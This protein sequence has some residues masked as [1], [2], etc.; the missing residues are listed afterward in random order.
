MKQL[1]SSS[2]TICID[3]LVYSNVI[4]TLVY[5]SNC[6]KGNALAKIS[7][8]GQNTARY[9]EHV[10]GDWVGQVRHGGVGTSSRIIWILTSGA[11]AWF[12]TR[13]PAKTYTEKDFRVLN[14]NNCYFLCKE[15][16]IWSYFLVFT[17]PFNKKSCR[18]EETPH[19]LSSRWIE[20]KIKVSCWVNEE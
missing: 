5:F 19:S 15:N 8:L 9:H 17:N 16:V 10:T 6:I 11:A 13:S 7:G 12:V 3:L 20:M 14:N 1:W 18:E 2:I 4:Q